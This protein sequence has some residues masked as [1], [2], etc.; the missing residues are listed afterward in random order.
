M[1]A[2]V[3]SLM[4]AF[5][6]ALKYQLFTSGTVLRPIMQAVEF[7][8]NGAIPLSSLVM[9]GNVAESLRRNFGIGGPKD[10]DVELIEQQQKLEEQRA[11]AE[12]HADSAA[13]GAG[14]P[15]TRPLEQM[16]FSGRASSSYRQFEDE[17]DDK[18]ADVETG[19]TAPSVGAAAAA[20]LRDPSGAAVAA[21]P[22]FAHVVAGA[23]H[24]SINTVSHGDMTDDDDAV[25]ARAHELA[26]LSISALA[27]RTDNDSVTE[28][29]L[30]R[31][32]SQEP[33]AGVISA[34][35]N[36]TTRTVH[37]LPG[38][39]HVPQLPSPRLPPYQM[40]VFLSLRLV[41]MP[42]CCFLLLQLADLAGVTWLAPKDPLLRVM[43]LLINLAP[44]AE[45]ILVV[46]TKTGMRRQALATSLLYLIQFGAVILT[47]T[48]GLTIALIVY[49]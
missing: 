21:R 38:D 16:S 18:F 35:L 42:T 29:H 13:M 2:T 48:I 19:G 24:F 36:V 25:T 41:I 28:I 32:V 23:P 49:F 4:I 27:L 31:V 40:A 5:W 7:I 8:G 17:Y 1:V 44:S 11:A 39:T 33:G 12:T 43:L 20:G 30:G 3:I 34:P 10:R 22:G 45:A 46:V 9:A 14:L 15:T 47:A 37:A 6:P 26:D